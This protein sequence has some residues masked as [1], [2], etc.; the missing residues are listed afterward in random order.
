[1]SM[2]QGHAFL[3]VCTFSILHPESPASLV[4]SASDRSNP[5]A[6]IIMFISAYLLNL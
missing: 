1:M 2:A 6:V 4:Q 3:K 5:F